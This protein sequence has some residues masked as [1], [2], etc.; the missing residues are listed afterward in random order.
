M[1]FQQASLALLAATV[2][3]LAGEVSLNS[4]YSEIMILHSAWEKYRQKVIMKQ[5]PPVAEYAPLM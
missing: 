5:T 1:R 2:L 4:S 3:D